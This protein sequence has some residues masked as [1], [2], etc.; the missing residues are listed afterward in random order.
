MGERKKMRQHH[1]LCERHSEGNV[2]VCI[3]PEIEQARAEERRAV[4]KL[5][6]YLQGRGYGQANSIDAGDFIDALNER[7]WKDNP[8][9]EG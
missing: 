7:S 6:I 1:P 3:C 2:K 8:Y 5:A 9:W 4:I